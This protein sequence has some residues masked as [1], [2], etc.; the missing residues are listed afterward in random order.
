MGMRMRRIFPRVALS[1]ALL[2]GLSGCF[3]TMSNNQPF[4]S[5][6][7]SQANSQLAE[8]DSQE[9]TD[10][11]QIEAD[12]QSGQE[13]DF[14][15]TGGCY[16][17]YEELGYYAIFE[18]FDD[19]CYLI[20]EVFPPEP[21]RYAELQYFDETWIEESSGETDSGG[22]LYLKVDPICDNG[23]WCDGVWEYRVA[24]EARGSLRA[25][26]S[27]VFELDFIPWE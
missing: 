14:R 17:S 24:L 21:A 11:S 16:N 2:A 8:T 10:N 15:I 6:S 4:S 23:L 25:E 27:P 19:D 9:Q 1:I 20:V 3:G 7:N 26:R 18:E 22:V 12:G 13:V 5:E